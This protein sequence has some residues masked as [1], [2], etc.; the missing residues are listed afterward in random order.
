MQPSVARVTDVKQGVA[1]HSVWF[2]QPGGVRNNLDA[3]ARRKG[4]GH[5]RF[6]VIPQDAEISLEFRQR[7]EI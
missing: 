2:G 4:R 7:C 6:H 5:W 1:E 3:L